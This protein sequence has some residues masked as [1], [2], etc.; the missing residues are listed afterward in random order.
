MTRE[1]DSDCFTLIQQ[2]QRKARRPNPVQ[3]MKTS[4][5]GRGRYCLSFFVSFSFSTAR[6]AESDRELKNDMRR[7]DSPAIVSPLKGENSKEA[8][9]LKEGQGDGDLRSE[10]VC[11]A[12]SGA[13]DSGVSR[14]APCACLCLNSRV[15]TW[16]A[17]DAMYS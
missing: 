6:V 1:F 5:R 12:V 10:R 17:V 16:R 4:R 13:V 3:T 2:R 15:A 9:D 7:F 14:L 11:Q 8:D